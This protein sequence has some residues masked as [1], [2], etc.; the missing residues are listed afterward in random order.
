MDILTKDLAMREVPYDSE[1]YQQMLIFRNMHMRIPIGLSLFDEDLSGEVNDHHIGVY[2]RDKL[3]G[4]CI[5]TPVS[6]PPRGCG[7][8]SLRRNTATVGSAV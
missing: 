1:Q 4:V 5:I 6:K 8:S 7:R 2:R 3:I